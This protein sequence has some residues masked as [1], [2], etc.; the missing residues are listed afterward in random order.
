MHSTKH[1]AHIP[2]DTLTLVELNNWSA[3]CTFQ[4]NFSWGIK[5]KKSLERKLVSEKNKGVTPCQLIPFPFTLFSFL[6]FLSTFFYCL[7]HMQFPTL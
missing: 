2:T 3:M 4:V 7:T 1:G 6:E 5:A